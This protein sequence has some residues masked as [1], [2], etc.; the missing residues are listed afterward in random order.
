MDRREYEVTRERGLDRDIDRFSVSNFSD[1]DDVGVLSECR[2]Q[3]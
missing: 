2:T 3:S 1:H